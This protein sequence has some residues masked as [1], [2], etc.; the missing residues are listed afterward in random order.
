MTRWA[1]TLLLLLLLAGCGPALTPRPEAVPQVRY[2]G[3][4]GT[5]ENRL[6]AFTTL[7]RSPS[8]NGRIDLAGR[9]GKLLISNDPEYLAA[10]AAFP[11]ALYRDELAGS[12]R[13]FY[14][15][16]NTTRGELILATAITNVQTA[17][18]LLF[19]RGSGRAIN[20]YPD[21]AGQ[22]A[23]DGYLKRRRQLTHLAT[24][25]P[26]ESLLIPSHP[27]R[28]GDT[29]SALEEYLAV[30]PPP[31]VDERASSL[32]LASALAA[33]PS[34][35]NAVGVKQPGLPAGFSLATVT[36]TVVAYK[37]AAPREPELLPVVPAAAPK[38][39]AGTPY[40]LL[41]RGTFPLSD[42][43]AEIAL[44]SDTPT[45][46]TVNSA[47]SGPFSHA[48]RGE[49]LLG[50]DAANGRKGFN[51]GNYGVLY[52]L[53]LCLSTDA[54]LGLPYAFLMQPAGGAGH[55]AL[56]AEGDIVRSPLVSYKSGWWFYRALAS[57][58]MSCLMLRAHLTGG[59]F[60]PQKFLFVPFAPFGLKGALMPGLGHDPL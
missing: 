32:E 19:S 11:A 7:P 56:Q 23:F 15:H 59:S 47:V 41:N 50:A 9:G 27:A 21:V 31:Q 36:V 40:Y 58:P 38:P 48:I 46:L 1:T 16:A 3:P 2:G 60:G 37:G 35:E 25:V 49:Y 39:V 55:Y 43:Y 26:G 30:T 20:P 53:R 14:H 45:M 44:A 54:P 5:S 8:L 18:L 24:L 28:P 13:V 57:P 22:Q 17:P 10:A 12:F 34:D 51:N 4:K 33:I 6:V 42:R 29:A 52:N